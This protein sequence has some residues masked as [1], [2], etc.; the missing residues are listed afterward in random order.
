MFPYAFL[1]IEYFKSIAYIFEQTT[2]D[3]QTAMNLCHKYNSIIGGFY[4]RK[5]KIISV[6]TE[7]CI[8]IG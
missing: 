6:G 4:T 3:E 2:D 7:I 8:G 5:I 1:I